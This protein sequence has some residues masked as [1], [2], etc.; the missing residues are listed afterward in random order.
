MRADFMGDSLRQG[1]LARDKDSLNQAV[2]HS[3]GT[4]EVKWIEW[5]DRLEGEWAK[6]FQ[7]SGLRE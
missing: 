1:G 6:D 4:L 7:V 2:S 3:P 5:V